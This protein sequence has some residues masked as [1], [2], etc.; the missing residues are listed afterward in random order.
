MNNQASTSGIHDV[1]AALRGGD[2]GEV[3]HLDYETVAK[4]S[5]I[6]LRRPSQSARI[7]QSLFES[8]EIV[9]LAFILVLT[10]DGETNC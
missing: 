6:I 3:K 10:R 5:S 7:R 1:T 2:S 9:V 8:I 4:Q